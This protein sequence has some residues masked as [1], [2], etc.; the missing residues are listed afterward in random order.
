[1][2]MCWLRAEARPTCWRM[3]DWRVIR[4]IPGF[5]VVFKRLPWIHYVTEADL[6]IHLPSSLITGIYHHIE[7]LVIL[8]EEEEQKDTMFPNPLG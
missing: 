3:R 1:M 2:F 6:L 8:K 7:N 4:T 5:V